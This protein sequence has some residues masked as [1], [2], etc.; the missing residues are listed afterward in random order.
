MY[1][2]RK[3]LA[4]AI[5]EDGDFTLEDFTNCNDVPDKRHFGEELEKAVMNRVKVLDP[6][7]AAIVIRQHTSSNILLTA[8][9]RLQA[10]YDNNGTSALELLACASLVAAIYDLLVE[11]QLDDPVDVLDTELEDLLLQAE[12][13]TADRL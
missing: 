10:K 3:K 13:I 8:P 1:N 5:I 12:V 2:L 6:K 7:S 9:D 11:D 4:E